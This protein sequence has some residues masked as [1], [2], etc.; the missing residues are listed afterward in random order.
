ML[1][2]FHPDIALVIKSGGDQPTM[3]TGCVERAYRAE[4]HLNQLKEM[5]QCMFEN[6]RRQGEQSGSRS[7][8]SRNKVY[9]V[10]SNKGR[11]CTVTKERG[12]IR[13]RETLANKLPRQQYY[14]PNLYKVWK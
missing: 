12:T 11:I 6:R 2:M 1:K 4:H 7:N 8:D 13:R 9:R 5:R 14:L 10:I 3:T